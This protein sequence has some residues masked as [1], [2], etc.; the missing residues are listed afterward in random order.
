[1]KRIL[2]AVCFAGLSL[3]QQANPRGWWEVSAAAQTS[4]GHVYHLR[5]Q[6]AMKGA[7]L[8]F[9]ADEIDYD[10]IKGTVH[11]AGHVSVETEAVTLRA[12]DIDY[13]VNSGEFHARRGDVNLKLKQ[14]P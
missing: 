8:L 10:E 12:D 2:L 6:A 4:D 14:V 3:G 1:M 13:D 5:G 9:R 7:G 11:L